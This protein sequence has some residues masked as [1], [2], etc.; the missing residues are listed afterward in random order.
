MT[1]PKKP[2]LPTIPSLTKKAD[3]VFS[4][5]IRR[6][7]TTQ[8]IEDEN[9]FSIR[10]GHCV[11]CNRLVPTEGKGTGHAGHFIE[12]GIKLT[13]YDPFNVHLQC[14]YC[15]TYK[16]GEQYKHSVYIKVHH[17]QEVL[18]KLITL[19]AQ[20]KREG[21]KFTRDELIGVIEVYTAKIAELATM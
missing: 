14:N 6:R 17:G 11:T 18:D 19:E 8:Y 21:H 9:G 1:K 7:D 20:Y 4:E 12:R 2:K 10:A 15:N 3:R 5:Y 16:Y 13:R